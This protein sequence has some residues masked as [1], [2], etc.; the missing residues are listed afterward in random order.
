MPR[1]KFTHSDCQRRVCFVCFLKKKTIKNITD[2]TREL[3]RKH[4]FPDKSLQINEDSFAWLPCVICSTCLTYLHRLDKDPSASF[5]TVDYSSLTSPQ[6]MRVERVTR[7]E[8][9]ETELSCS[10][11][12]CLVGHM[13]NSGKIYVK[14]KDIMTLE[15]DGGDDRVVEENAVAVTRCEYCFCP[16]GKGKPHPCSSRS[17]RESLDELVRNSSDRTRGRV[18]STQLKSLTDERNVPRGQETFLPTGGKP[19]PVTVGNPGQS[20]KPAPF[21]SAQKLIR[22]QTKLSC[23]DSK[24]KE[25]AKFARIECGKSAVESNF[26]T[27]LQD[28]NHLF[29]DDFIGKK[30]S[31]LEHEKVDTDEEKENSKKRKRK[32]KAQEVMKEKPAVFAKDV[33]DLTA[34][35]MMFRNLNPV[36]TV[37]Q[38]GIDDCQGLLKVGI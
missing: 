33:E 6:I 17:R 2:T 34:K 14:F 30:I 23:S 16:V 32:V 10:C 7:S 12:V 37:V 28:R 26:G 11:S 38:I 36:D 19:L 5:Q 29:D 4:L 15:K 13:D 31:M 21:F 1:D 3:I 35:I 9:L 22:L 18:L 25:I 24:I 27:F 20:K 8:G